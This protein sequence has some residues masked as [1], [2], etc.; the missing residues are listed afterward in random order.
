MRAALL[1]EAESV[2]GPLRCCSTAARPPAEVTR[3]AQLAGPGPGLGAAAR[4]GLARAGLGRPPLG[5][6]CGAGVWHGAEAEQRSQLGRAG[7]RADAGPERGRRAGTPW[8]PL[9]GASV[10]P[11]A[12]GQR[13][14]RALPGPSSVAMAGVVHLQRGA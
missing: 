11:K 9:P 1:R 3:Q 13:C 5:A 2:R 12:G 7:V 4:A 8:L 10:R 14:A 6:A